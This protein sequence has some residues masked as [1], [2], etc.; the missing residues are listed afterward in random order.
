MPRFLLLVPIAALTAQRMAF[1]A[2]HH[3]LEA[4]RD[5]CP[6]GPHGFLQN[7]GI[8][9]LEGVPFFQ[10]TVPGRGGFFFLPEGRLLDGL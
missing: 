10:T 6:H 7:Q 2:V 1:G 9:V 5:Y 4:G 3:P 8:M